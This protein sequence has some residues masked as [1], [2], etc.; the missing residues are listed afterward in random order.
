MNQ[1]QISRVNLPPM[2]AVR[3]L[4]QI[5]NPELRLSTQQVPLAVTPRDAKLAARAVRENEAKLRADAKKAAAEAKDAERRERKAAESAARDA[6][7][8]LSGQANQTVQTVKQS[9]S[10]FTSMSGLG[11]VLTPVLGVGFAVYLYLSATGGGVSLDGEAKKRSIFR[12]F[13]VLIGVI[14]AVTILRIAKTV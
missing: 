9:L 8:Q 13:D 5:P 2:S 10:D 7:K 14:V 11:S 4:S 6:A 1:P 3:E 12:W